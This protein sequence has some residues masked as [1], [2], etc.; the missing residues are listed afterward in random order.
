MNNAFPYQFVADV[1]LNS[2]N[3]SYPNFLRDIVKRSDIS[4][5]NKLKEFFDGELENTSLQNQQAVEYFIFVAKHALSYYFFQR[6]YESF[7]NAIDLIKH[8]MVALRSVPS[9]VINLGG[10]EQYLQLNLIAFSRLMRK[11]PIEKFE[12][13]I[14]KM[15]WSGFDQD[16]IA[17]VSTIVGFVYLNE[18]EPDQVVKSRLWLQKSIRESEFEDNLSNLLFLASHYLQ[19]RS[20][21]NAHSIEEII[22]QLSAGKDQI[23]SAPVQSIFDAAIFELKANLLSHVFANFDD[24][25][26]KLEHSQQ[27]LRDLESQY[28][29]RS[30]NWLPE[31]G[32][33]Y[34]DHAIAKL[35]AQLHNMT[36][37]DLEQASFARNSMKHIERAIEKAEAVNDM[38]SVLNHRL[39]R[40]ELAAA[41]S[42]ALTEKEIREIVQFNKKSGDYPAYVR[43]CKSYVNLLKINDN[44]PKTYDVISDLFKWGTKKMDGEG[45]FYL[46]CSGMELAN[47]IFIEETHKPGVS[48]MVHQLDN[49]FERVQNII[50]S[51]DDYIQSIGISQVEKFRREYL[52]FE[53]VSH[54]NIKVYYRYQLYQIKMMRIGARIHKDA[55]TEQLATQMIN[56]LENQSNPIHF[57]TADWDEFKDVPNSVR[58]RTLNKCINI[59]KGDL[60]LAAEHLDFSYRNLRSYITFKEVNRLGF[61]LEMQQTNNRQ[62]EQ[63]IRYMFYDL[64]KRGTIFEVVFDMPRFLVKYS[65]SG[66][67]SQDLERELKIKGT[68]AKKYIKIMMEIKLI[69]QDKTTGRKHYYRLI[70]EN[71]MNRLGKDQTTLIKPQQQT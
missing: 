32:K 19:E 35:Y 42:S 45:G 41:T 20:S 47:D 1:S 12:S 24:P 36:N 48:W 68:T 2:G 58:N 43:S 51:L 8:R 59:S 69:R 56:S 21:E 18:E 3:F 65:K 34:I 6:N 54:F 16:F 5:F 17:N 40:A 14:D 22:K 4:D 70:R 13:H 10:W 67:Y 26:T 37:D 53:P 46:I 15:D 27:E 62:L 9:D 38:H 11:V 39:A 44:S 52:R 63:G 7:Q 60:P 33:A 55:L 30:Q 25:L 28:H 57:I 50:N 29:H 31:F 71:V 23:D 49:F 64:Y 61:F 66:F